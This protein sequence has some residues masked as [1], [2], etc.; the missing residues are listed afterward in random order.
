MSDELV[1]IHVTNVDW[2]AEMIKNYLEEAGVRVHVASE[3]VRHLIGLVADGIGQI[4]L[5]VV[6]GDEAQARRLLDEYLSQQQ[7]PEQQ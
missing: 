4:R 3:S 7:A 5:Q 1:T 2:E 6:A